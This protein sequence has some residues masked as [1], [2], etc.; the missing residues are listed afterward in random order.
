MILC[1]LVRKDLWL[2]RR[3]CALAALLS[4]L[5]A[6]LALGAPEIARV[7]LSLLMAAVIGVTFHFPIVTVLREEMGRSRAWVLSLPVSPA[8]YAIAKL[9]ANAVLFTLSV[10]P[11]V[12]LLALAPEDRHLLPTPMILLMATGLLVWFLRTIGLSLATGSMAWTMGL[13]AVDLALVGNGVSYL[14]ARVPSV[15]GFFF[16]VMGGGP[17][18][19]W[20]L[21]A[22]FA[23]VALIFAA[24][25][26]A[27]V[28]TRD[29]C[30]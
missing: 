9:L 21:A 17:A 8:D 29:F 6:A 15:Q 1:N 13:L 2:Q 25:R 28:R 11:A 30:R 16:Q 20:A 3:A 23:Q 4:T 14:A 10:G 5:G 22:L 24:T 7:G 12:L 27:F 26:F 19:L 18:F